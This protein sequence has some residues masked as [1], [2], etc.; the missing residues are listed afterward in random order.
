MDR[1]LV[2]LDGYRDRYSNNKTQDPNR[3]GSPWSLAV[4]PGPERDATGRNKYLRWK[5]SDVDTCEY[6]GR[7]LGDHHDGLSIDNLPEEL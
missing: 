6:I 5:R 2:D 1:T 3:H 7:W 4:E